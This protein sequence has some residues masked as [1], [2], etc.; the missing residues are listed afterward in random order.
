ME[1]IDAVDYLYSKNAGPFV[2]TFDIA[3]KNRA[4][5]DAAVSAGVFTREAMARQLRIP[6]SRILSIHPYPAANIVKF[7]ITR[8]APSGS[9]GENTVFGS[10]LWPTLIDFPI[11][12]L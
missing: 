6:E 12:E 5:F 10:Q 1:L 11:P 2:I 4:L 9:F 3:F 7:S 8:T